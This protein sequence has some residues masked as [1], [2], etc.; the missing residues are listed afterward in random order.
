MMNTSGLRLHQMRALKRAAK[1]VEREDETAKAH[2][3]RLRAAIDKHPCRR[4]HR[5]IGECVARGD[6][7]KAQRLLEGAPARYQAVFWLCRYAA[8]A[9]VGRG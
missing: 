7:G 9:V 4:V 1:T 6:L 5:A 2:E 8:R 3:R